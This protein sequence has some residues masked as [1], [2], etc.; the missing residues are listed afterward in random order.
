MCIRDSGPP[1]LHHP[2]VGHH[3]RLRSPGGGTPAHR[4]L[5]GSHLPIRGR[6]LGPIRGQPVAEKAEDKGSLG[7]RASRRQ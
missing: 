7:P 4:A 6:P 3:R 1:S 5:P 2:A